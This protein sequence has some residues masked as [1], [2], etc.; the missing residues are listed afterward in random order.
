MKT[1]TISNVN[2]GA[3]LNRL[4]VSRFHWCNTLETSQHSLEDVV[5]EPSAPEPSPDRTDSAGAHTS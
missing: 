5:P 3:R 1:S 4:S 2:A